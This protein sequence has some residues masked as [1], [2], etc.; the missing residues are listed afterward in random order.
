M[1]LPIPMNDGAINGLK[2]MSEEWL[3]V[4]AKNGNANAFAELRNRH[5]GKLLRTTYRI[6]RN[7][8]DAEDALQDCFLKAFIHLNRFEGRSS[9]LSWLTKIAINMS[10]D[11]MRRRR[12]KKG[13]SIDAGEHAYQSYDRWELRDLSEDPECRYARR[14]RAELIRGA[15]RQLCPNL[16][17]I[18]ELQL[19]REY[20]TREL[21]NSLGISLAAAKSRLLRAKLSMCTSLQHKGATSRRGK[22]CTEPR[23]QKI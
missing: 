1:N 10:L 9:F 22:L 11:T 16:R 19:E 15:M 13:F 5:F 8:D 17:V 18:V 2:Q 23:G 12:V 3:V 14:E 20:S 21:A 4:A 6:T 7:P